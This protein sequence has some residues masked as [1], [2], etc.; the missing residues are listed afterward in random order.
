M[1]TPQTSEAEDDLKRLMKQWVQIQKDKYGDNW[2]K[3]L[4]K[5]MAEKSTPFLNLF[6]T[7]E[8]K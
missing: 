7:K 1:P 8:K 2:K 4:A 3:V 5:D 6:F